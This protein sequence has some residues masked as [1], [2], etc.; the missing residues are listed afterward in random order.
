MAKV[1]KNPSELIMS[2]VLNHLPSNVKIIE[3]WETN[4]LSLGKQYD[5]KL[6]VLYKYGDSVLITKI[7]AHDSGAITKRKKREMANR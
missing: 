4:G 3:V 5:K 1:I 6:V 7:S 2:I